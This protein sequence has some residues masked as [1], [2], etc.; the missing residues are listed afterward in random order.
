MSSRKMSK[1]LVIVC[2][3]FASREIIR[4]MNRLVAFMPQLPVIEAGQQVAVI[5]GAGYIGSYLAP[6]LQSHGFRV[7]IFDKDPKFQEDDLHVASIVKVH[8]KNLQPSDLSEF[9]TVIFLGGCTGR[10]TC[11]EISVEEVEEENIWAVI[12]VLKKMSS[13][14]HFISASTSAIAEGTFNANEKSPVNVNRLDRYSL[15]MF[16][17][18]I[19]LQEHIDHDY[20]HNLPRVSLLRFGTVVGNS[21]AQ[22]TDLMVPSF[23]FSAYTSGSLTV[24]GH[25]KMRSFLTLQDLSR[26]MLSLIS[27][28]IELSYSI[29]NL[30]SFDATTLKIASTVASLTGA[31]ID[32]DKLETTPLL[33]QREGFSLVCDAFRNA[34]NFTFDGSLLSTLT[35]FDRSIP[36]SITPKGPHEVGSA[37]DYSDIVPCPVCG[38]GGQQ[39]VIDLGA[40]PLANDFMGEVNAALARP[41]F[42]LKLVRCRV[43]NHYHLSHVVDRSDLFHHYL[44]TSG[45]SKTLSDYFEWLAQKV[46]GEAIFTLGSTGSI[47]EI[48][49]ND[50]SQLDHFKAQG[51]KTFGVD[52]AENLA[53][54]AAK[55][56]IVRNGFWP[57]QFP[58]LPRGNDLTAITAQ[59]VL[60]HV[61]NVVSFLK[62][63][64]D[65]MGP[66][67]KLYVQTSQCNMQ[68]LGQFDTVYHEHI[69]FFTGHSFLKAAQLAGL[70]ILSFETTP[71]HGESCLVTMQL[72]KKGRA[73]K[74]N[75]A[76]AFAIDSQSTLSS[77]SSLTERLQL[78]KDAGI[79]SDFF[80]MKFGAH[81]NAIR[82]W[83]KS[84]LLRFKQEQYNVCGYGAAAK[85]M[86]LLHYILDNKDDGSSYLDF[87]IDDASLKQNTYCPGTVIPVYSTSNITQVIKPERPVVIL[88]FAWNFFQEISS[89]VFNSLKDVQQEVFF[90]VPFPKPQVLQAEVTESGI[91]FDVLR[92]MPFWPTQI[93]NPITADSNRS[94]AIMITHQRNEELLMPF[95][96]MH[97]APMFDEVTLIDFD[98]DDHTLAIIERYAP[99]SW[100][101]EKSST[102]SVFDA[103]ATDK[104][105]ESFESVHPNDWVVAL[106]TTEFLIKAN[107]RGYLSNLG[108]KGP[109]VLPI[110]MI[111]INGDNTSPLSYSQSLPRQ[112]HV[113]YIT[114]DSRFMH[115]KTNEVYHYGPGRHSYNGQGAD[116]KDIDDAFIMKFGF[117]PWPE[118]KERKMNVGKTIPESDKAVGF[119]FQH[120]A[121][122]GN[123]DKLEQEYS[124]ALVASTLNFC[125]GNENGT[126]ER[127]F[128]LAYH[129]ALGKCLISMRNLSNFTL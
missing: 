40:Q 26:A 107:L 4:S 63:C 88:V 77:S 43:C 50:G 103:V 25:D 128:R 68:Q 85:G 87:V 15:S 114:S 96:I 106:T 64:K 46:I 73:T 29:W 89:R 91:K 38:S 14:Q 58:E 79:V 93:P 74:Q 52:P 82:K 30:A 1:M 125:Y 34:F 84:E 99:P 22:R 109:T 27:K 7:T 92:E 123:E 20:E 127:M 81:A 10:K 41:R 86:V 31:T 33:S 94:R 95:F 105:V 108:V 54:I 60:A 36:S 119:G 24:Q 56:H 32:S 69:S 12:D 21:P 102:G 51:W 129:G 67:T 62:G 110:R 116:T 13:G 48:A 100:K 5:G 113:G 70:E 8:S 49:C 101:L 3:L 9:G 78:E 59:N 42:P 17:R 104:Q 120:T 47:L 16:K 28:P 75:E 39:I 18:E 72:L 97:H 122:V 117:A 83:I 121:R 112:R 57:L 61:P 80:P 23:F 115:F 126:E 71:I 44:Y 118:V 98:S 65:V 55:N 35:E 11:S 124:D 45:T 6:Y 66:N 19:R 76:T 37:V 2:V 53:A 90:I 111:S